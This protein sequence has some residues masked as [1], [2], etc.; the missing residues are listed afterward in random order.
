MIKE[1]MMMK[2]KN[3]KVKG[4]HYI[5]KIVQVIFRP[6]IVVYFKYLFKVK[7]KAD[8]PDILN[9]ELTVSLTTYSTR[10]DTV[11]YCIKS[12]L[13]QTIKP[14]RIVLWLSKDEFNL[15][16]LPES[17]LSLQSEGLIIDF[18]EDFKSHK[19][20]FFS[21]KKW[22]E[23][24]VVTVD[25]DVFYPEDMLSQLV[26][27]YNKYPSAISCFR[28]HEIIIEN[29]KILKYSN[30][31][32]TSPGVQGPTHR[33]FQIGVNGVLYPPRS[34][35][36]DI[37]DSTTFMK[38]CAN[39]DDL[40][41]KIMALRNKTK[42]VKVKPYSKTMIEIPQTQKISLSSSNVIHGNNDQQLKNIMDAYDL[43]Y[44][45]FKEE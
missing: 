19:K 4:S 7:K 24:L 10:I 8:T 9:R 21:M 32:F 2:T 33:L 26:K 29:N 22:P 25:D 16:M 44:R 28:A 3:G 42:V 27:S 6:L 45:V 13:K 17:L 1:I 20:Y 23:S 11:H 39:A 40:W 38:I 43:D 14:T 18:C 34:L 30:W 41:L 15:S 36:K 31:N 5:D 12:L 37:F 35:H